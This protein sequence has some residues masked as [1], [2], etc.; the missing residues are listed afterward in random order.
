MSVNLYVCV[1]VR[2]SE[3]S[4]CTCLLAPDDPTSETCY[5]RERL[6]CLFYLLWHFLFCLL[7]RFF[8][9]CA[10]LSKRVWHGN[11]RD[12]NALLQTGHRHDWDALAT[13]LGCGKTPLSSLESTPSHHNKH[14]AICR[15]VGMP[16]SA[17][18]LASTTAL[19]AVWGHQKREVESVM[20]P[21]KQQQQMQPHK[22]VLT[23][24]RKNTGQYHCLFSTVLF[25]TAMS[26]F[27]FQRWMKDHN[28]SVLRT[29]KM[30]RKELLLCNTRKTI[31]PFHVGLY[32]F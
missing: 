17:R 24:F 29:G 12:R 22:S 25:K 2:V 3:L 15:S 14:P 5:N 16:P 27:W 13:V 26:V 1:C 9:F 21:R 23:K 8:L 19:P 18:V 10:L 11:G 31:I 30:P 7:W 32:I 4:W 6:N 20:S 28:Y